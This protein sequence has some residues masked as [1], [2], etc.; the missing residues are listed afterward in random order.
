LIALLPLEDSA[1]SEGE[2]G[3]GNTNINLEE[4]QVISSKL[5]KVPQMLRCSWTHGRPTV[6]EVSDGHNS[7]EKAGFKPVQRPQRITSTVLETATARDV[8]VGNKRKG[9]TAASAVPDLAV[10]EDRGVAISREQ[11][12]AELRQ[13]AAENVVV[14]E[15]TVACDQPAPAPPPEYFRTEVN[16]SS[17]GGKIPSGAGGRMKTKAEK[18]NKKKGGGPRITI[19]PDDTN[20]DAGGNCTGDLKQSMRAGL[21]TGPSIKASKPRLEPLPPRNTA[22]IN[23]GSLHKKPKIEEKEKKAAETGDASVLP[24]LPPPAAATTAPATASD[25]VKSWEEWLAPLGSNEKKQEQQPKFG[26]RGKNK[27]K[28]R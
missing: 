17:I 24:S 13:T 9:T 2:G 28:R 18:Q 22:F 16:L 3:D 10:N 12:M 19:I 23:V 1:R 21:S 11:L 15:E 26:S 14:L 7:S 6:I 27:A 5:A 20:N 8:L 4:S 25:N